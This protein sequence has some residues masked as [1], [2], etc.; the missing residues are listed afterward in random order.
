M[1]VYNG[2]LFEV[3]KFCKWDFEIVEKYYDALCLMFVIASDLDKS[4]R[5]LN[6]LLDILFYLKKKTVL[7]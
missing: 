3:E 1:I 5:K 7:I 6:W 2:G 4:W